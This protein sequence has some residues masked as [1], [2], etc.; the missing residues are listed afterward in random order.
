MEPVLDHV[1]S[2]LGQLDDLASQRP[3]VVAAEGMAAAA[4]LRRAALDD[5]T[6]PLGRDDR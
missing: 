5:G 1:G 4:A 6:Q 2:D 3:R